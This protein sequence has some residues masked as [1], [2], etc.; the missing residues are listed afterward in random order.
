MTLTAQTA[1]QC[2]VRPV[3]YPKVYRSTSESRG[4]HGDAESDLPRI[5]GDDGRL[6]ASDIQTAKSNQTFTAAVAASRCHPK[7]PY[8]R[9]DLRLSLLLHIILMKL[10]GPRT[11]TIATVPLSF[12]SP[13]HHI[14]SNCM[15]WMHCVKVQLVTR[16]AKKLQ[17]K[18]DRRQGQA[19]NQS[20]SANDCRP[21]KK[22]PDLFGA[23]AHSS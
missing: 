16:Y 8:T 17:S 23:K 9:P 13:L 22:A 4:Q 1:D 6:Q 7:A 19:C 5:R 11:P 10:Y 12:T 15:A 20:H 18:Y 21:P 2:F 3:Q 14:S